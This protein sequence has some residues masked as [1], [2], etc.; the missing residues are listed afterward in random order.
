MPA[1]IKISSET[2]SA[3]RELHNLGRTVPQM[4]AELGLSKWLV[5]RVCAENQIPLN[6][7]DKS[8]N[9]EFQQKVKDLWAQ[10]FPIWK[11]GKTLHASAETVSTA[12]KLLKLTPNPL[13]RKHS[14][15]DN[16]EICLNCTRPTCK[17]TC[18]KFM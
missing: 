3:V 13:Q 5:H 9:A 11:I 8:Y 10:G 14:Y 17:G 7:A 18:E 2:V 6:G 15:E 4:A 12:L 1:K 16:P